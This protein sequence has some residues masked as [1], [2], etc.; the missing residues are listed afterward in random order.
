MRH[1]L[2]VLA[3]PALSWRVLT[4]A[5]L[6][7]VT[8]IGLSGASVTADTPVYADPAGACNGLTPCF[9]TIQKAVNEVDVGGEVFVFPGAYAESVNLNEMNGG[10]PG[11]ISLTTVV[12]VRSRMSA[13]R[14][15]AARN[16]TVNTV[17][18]RMIQRRAEA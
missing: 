13:G 3:R 17:R 16:N 18:K 5:V 9:T 7:A 8:A 12:M 6:I 14:L 4:S 1:L 10:S 11:T 15:M 2:M